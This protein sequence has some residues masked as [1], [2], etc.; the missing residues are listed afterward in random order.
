MLQRFGFNTGAELDEPTLRAIAE[1]TG[2]EY[3]RARS[4]SEL[5]AIGATLD[6]LE[7][8]AQ[9]PKQ[10]RV[11]DALYVWPLS[12]ALLISLMLVANNLWHAALHRL[13]WRRKQP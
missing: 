2:G 5:E 9:Q 1:Q 7:P 12:A 4:S 11:A 13:F 3:F 8:V 6:Q 10:A